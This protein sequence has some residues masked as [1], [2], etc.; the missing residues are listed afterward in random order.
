[1]RTKITKAS[2]RTRTGEA[3]PRAEKFGH[4]ITADH[5]V[6]NEGGESRD[7]HRYA[8]VVQ[9]LATQKIQSYPCKTKS[10]HET[11]NSLLKFLEPSQ[12]P[13]V[14]YTDN[15]MEFGR[16]CEV[17]SWSHRT[18]TC[19]R[20]ETNGIADRAVPRV[21][22]GTSTVLLQSGLDE[23]WWSDSM[24]CYCYL[25]NAQDLLPD[26]KTPYERRFGKPFKGRMVPFGAMV[27]YQPSSPKD[28]ASVHQF[29]TGE[30]W[31]GDILIA[32]LEDLEKLDETNI[33]PRR[34]TQRNY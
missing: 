24:E 15:S 31:E 4:L 3:L 14:V 18:S 10:S 29:G 17:L 9:D 30:I 25:R 34:I 11:E 6:L 16:A 21:K 26:G 22:E 8:F 12:A 5:K 1:M 28:Q 19:H 33:Y 13:K 27:E 23:R 32:D 2:C 7:N 20:L